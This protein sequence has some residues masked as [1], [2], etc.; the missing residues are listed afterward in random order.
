MPESTETTARAGPAEEMSELVIDVDRPQRIA[1][2]GIVD[3]V[4]TPAFP[5]PGERAIDGT[6]EGI[7]T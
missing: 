3:G 7:D 2:E 1:L 6:Q 5:G 4:G